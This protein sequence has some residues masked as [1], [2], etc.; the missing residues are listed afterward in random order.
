MKAA[1]ILTVMIAVLLMPFTAFC[2]DEMKEFTTTPITFYR[3]GYFDTG[4]VHT[5]SVTAIATAVS[6]TSQV[7]IKK[8]D[9]GYYSLQGRLEGAGQVS[10][11]YHASNDG[12]IFKR[13]EGVTAFITAFKGSGNTS[14][15]GPDADGYFI[16]SFTVIP[17][18]AIQIWI[19]ETGFSQG[20]SPTKWVLGHQ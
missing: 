3:P 13:P 9:V 2:L 16:K 8:E 11:E 15:S 18:M 1:K 6:C 20:V 19:T 12:I 4:G 7:I 14:P 10:V 5:V 17:C